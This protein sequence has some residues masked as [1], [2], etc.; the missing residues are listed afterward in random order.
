M[1]LRLLWLLIP[2]CPCLGLA[3][4]PGE[5]NPAG[6]PPSSQA[7]NPPNV[8]FIAID[9]LNDWVGC[10]QGHPQV[11]TPNIDRLAE[12]GVLF[13]N[14]HCQAPICN[15]S[16]VSLL[17]GVLPSTSGVY[18]LNQ[19]HHLAPVL[20]KAVTLPAHFKANGYQ[21]LGR[22]KIYHGAYNYPK[23]WHDFKAAGDARNK[24]FRIKPVS[25]VP[26]IKVRDFG[27]IDLPEEQFG[28]LMNSRW[29]ARQ[30]Q[31]DFRKP[32]FLAVGIRLPHVPLYAPGRFFARHPEAKVLLPEVRTDDLGDLPPAGLEITRYMHGTPLNHRSITAS[33]NWKN[34]VRAYLAC[35][36][37]VDHCVGVIL[38]ALGESKYAKNTI[39][40][41][42]SDHGWHLGEKEHW[43]KRSLWE[44]STR[45]P[46]IFSGPGIS[47]GISRRAV[48]LID[49][50][51]TLSE[52]CS[53]PSPPQELEGNSLVPLLKNPMQE[54]PHA[55]LT[56]FHRNDHGLRTERWRYIRYASGEEELYDHLSDPNEWTN[57]AKK[58]EHREIIA[59]LRRK[60]PGKNAPDAPTR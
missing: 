39:I 33:G 32:F 45:V 26:G 1:K 34:A 6:R 30:L 38:K 28:D 48:G 23:D 54:W 3:D 8:L 25:S 16:R 19:P 9:D 4:K 37:F 24:Q 10:L 59:A 17:T 36:E 13:A 22:G 7:G 56:T 41:L 57:L 11:N 31:K 27:P 55:V 58:P 49:L 42:W 21:A 44:E 29:A 2:A 12:G 40:V 15:P 20:E 5:G 18:D 60:L 46:L 50:Y 43:A 52:L 51:P 53:L 14:A 47:K 35:T